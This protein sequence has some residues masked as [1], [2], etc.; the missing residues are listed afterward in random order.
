MAKGNESNVLNARL[1]LLEIDYSKRGAN[2]AD[3]Q[4]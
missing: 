4:A 1:F 3:L 2:H